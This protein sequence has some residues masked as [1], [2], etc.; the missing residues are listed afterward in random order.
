MLFLSIL[1][2][3][4]IVSDK[5]ADKSRYWLTYLLDDLPIGATFSPSALHLTIV[6]WF[7]T[8]VDEA[9][10]TQSFYKQFTRQEK[11]EISVGEIGEFNHKRKIPI[12]F[13]ESNDKLAELHDRSLAWL[14]SLEARWAVKTPHVGQDYIPH[15]RRR[16]GKNVKAGQKL[17]I[18]SLSLIRAHRRGDDFR[19]VIAK[20]KFDAENTT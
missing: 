16:P 2:P 11:I 5:K 6:P 18:D 17:G 13:I 3:D 15:I 14:R 9:S 20:V 10:L 19:I 8:D 4:L 7:V 12:S 1:Q